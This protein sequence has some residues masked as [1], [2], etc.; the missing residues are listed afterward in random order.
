MFSAAALSRLSSRTGSISGSFNGSLALQLQLL[1]ETDKVSFAQVAYFS[2]TYLGFLP[3]IAT[4]QEAVNAISLRGISSIPENPYKQI[5]YQ[6][7]AQICMNTWIKKGG[8]MYS[9][10]KSPRYAFREM[11]SL[12]LIDYQKY[13]NQSLSGK[14]ALNIMSKC[15]TIYE[16]ENSK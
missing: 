5:T 6:K 11:Q 4:E 15:I 9:I 7:F 13:P 12:G 8:L 14:E 16:K 1:H 3:D 10:T 2:A